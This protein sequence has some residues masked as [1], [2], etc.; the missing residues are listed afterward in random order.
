MQRLL[1]LTGLSVLMTVSIFAFTGCVPSAHRIAE[2]LGRPAECRIFIERVDEEVRRAG[3]SDAAFYPLPGFPY[4]R[5]SRFLAALNRDLINDSQRRALVEWM[6]ELDSLSRRKEILNMP[7]ASVRALLPGGRPDREE[8]ISSTESCCRSLF[9]NDLSHPDFHEKLS[10]LVDV[11]DEYSTAMR[12][13]GL[14]P[15]AYIPENIITYNVRETIRSWFETPPEKLPVRGRLKTYAPAIPGITRGEDLGAILDQSRKNPLNVP[16]PGPGDEKM[17]ALANAPVIVQ[18][19]AAP[20]DEMGLV[21]W[22]GKFPSIDT[23]N[24][25]VYYYTSH[26][27]LGKTPVMQVNY[28]F[29]YPERAGDRAPWIEH[30]RLDGLT[31]RIS[32][33]PEGRPFMWDA[34]HNCGCYHLFAPKK[35]RVAAIIPRNFAVDPFVPA[36]MPEMKKGER[37][38]LRV[39]TGWH[40]VEGLLASSPP[41]D[42][43]HYELRP[44]DE[45]ESLPRGEGARESLFDAKG[46]GKGTDRVEPY[47]FFPMGIPSIGSMRQRGHHAI[48]LSGRAHFDD[49]DLFNVNF[50]FK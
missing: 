49:P 4:L 13:F 33:D 39:M 5:T 19:V 18:D 47:I 3:S 16:R 36:W 22:R 7:D 25:A 30:G 21:V 9:E 11:P 6:R 26:A 1:K 42:A 43:I 8:L 32:L 29:W 12:V 24:P 48:L 45:L 2:E 14:Y 20:Y 28:V 17:L 50:I 15:L 34:M 44:Y 46:I 23:S 35:E 31:L 40:Q 27:L 10:P 38:L 41:G 37:P